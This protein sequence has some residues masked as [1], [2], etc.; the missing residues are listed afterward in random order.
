MKETGYSYEDPPIRLQYQTPV[1]H[2]QLQGHNS[3]V[4]IFMQFLG[5]FRFFFHVAHFFLTDE[6]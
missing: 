3:Q 4:R 6:K 1:R 5:I 2:I